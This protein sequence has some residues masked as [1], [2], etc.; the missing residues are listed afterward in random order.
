MRDEE[1]VVAIVGA[2]NECGY[3]LYQS[4][5]ERGLPV[6]EWRLYDTAEAIAAS[7]EDDFPMRVLADADFDGVDVAFLCGGSEQSAAEL[8]RVKRA[9]AVA[10]DVR[11]AFAGREDAV[12]MVPEVNSD[13]AEVAFEMREVSCPVPGAAALS[14]V[15]NPIEQAAVLRRVVVTCLES[16]GTAEM[17]SGIRSTKT[18]SAPILARDF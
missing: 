9:G 3:D 5:G 10:I 14:I 4:A 16:V 2:A 15:L 6:A 12:L 13:V 17:H 8:P 11:H 7:P 18:P 1:I